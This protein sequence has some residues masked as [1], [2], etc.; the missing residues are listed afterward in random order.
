MKIYIAGPITGIKPTVYK[1]NFARA[2]EEVLSQGHAPISPI[3]NTADPRDKDEW[4]GYM[5]AGLK[6]LLDCDAILMID[7]WEKSRGARIEFWTAATLGMPI[8]KMG[9]KL[10]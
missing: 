1:R 8:F 10:R 2:C 5:R 3:G 7:G 9:E 6:Q 4:V